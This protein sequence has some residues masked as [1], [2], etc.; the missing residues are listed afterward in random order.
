MVK[1]DL[2]KH[3]PLLATRRARHKQNGQDA[4]SLQKGATHFRKHRWA[5]QHM[6]LRHTPISGAKQP[7]QTF[8]ENQEVTPVAGGNQRI[9][10][11]E[12]IGPGYPGLSHRFRY[13]VMPEASGA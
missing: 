1:R 12:L 4:S 10:N 5:P 9:A 6:S 7:K 13:R 3:Q 8:V 11:Q 2:N